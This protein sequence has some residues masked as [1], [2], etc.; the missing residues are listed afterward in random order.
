MKP[1]L[2][3]L[4]AIQSATRALLVRGA[5][6]ALEPLFQTEALN[7]HMAWVFIDT[8]IAT[9]S[10]VFPHNFGRGMDYEKRSMTL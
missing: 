2:P 1:A 4:I 9:H 3:R 5:R 6:G 8:M 7:F 10:T